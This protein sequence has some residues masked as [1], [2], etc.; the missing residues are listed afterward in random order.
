MQIQII[1]EENKNQD[2]NTAQKADV[3]VPVRGIN[4]RTGRE[5]K[6]NNPHFRLTLYL[7]YPTKEQKERL[8]NM[9]KAFNLENKMRMK[10]MLKIANTPSE[11]MEMV[12]QDKKN[13]AEAD[14]KYRVWLR[15]KRKLDEAQYFKEFTEAC[16]AYA[17]AIKNS[18]E[19]E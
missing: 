15:R 13:R 17:K 10:R 7:A 19:P 16:M 11:A 6:T 3:N 1:E 5:L 12:M 9:A 14:R 2:N 18:K 4:K 8:H